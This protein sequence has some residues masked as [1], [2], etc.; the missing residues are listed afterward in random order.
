MFTRRA[1]VTLVAML[2][3]LPGIAA[4]DC[5]NRSGPV[6]ASQLSDDA[7]HCQLALVSRHLPESAVAVEVARAESVLAA[8]G[9][10]G[11]RAEVSADRRAAIVR[12]INRDV[13][14]TQQACRYWSTVEERS[15]PNAQVRK[16][17]LALRHVCYRDLAVVLRA[18][19]MNWQEAGRDRLAGFAEAD[20]LTLIEYRNQARAQMRAT[21]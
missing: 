21:P 6:F 10:E 17:L 1:K 14:S 15:L 3:A 19:M 5:A 16:D 9:L 20:L 7:I 12:H 11:V 13:K 2:L 8:S 18:E 4:A